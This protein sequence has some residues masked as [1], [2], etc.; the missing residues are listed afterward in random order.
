MDLT[1]QYMGLRLRSP[2][3]ASAAPLN[4]EIETLRALEDNGA[5]AV[6]LPSIFEEQIIAEQAECERATELSASGFAEAQTYFT[7]YNGYGFGAE[8]YLDMVRRAK[9]TIEIPVIASLNGISDAGWT[10][11]ARRLQE[12]GANALELNIYLIP[13]NVMTSGRDVEQHYLDVLAAV[14]AVVSIPVAVK[15]GPYFSS[16]GSMARALADGGADALVLFNRFYQPDFDVV[17]LRLS[18][19]LDLSTPAEMRLPLLWTAILHGR[20]SASL[21]ASTGVDSAEDVLKYL[22]AGADTVMTTSSLLRHGTGHMRKLVE[23]LAALLD[24]RNIRSLDQIRGRM[25]QQTI[26][27]PTAFERANYIHLLQGYHVA[28]ASSTA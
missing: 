5:G 14:K 25:S 3:I 19:A 26:K 23:G 1:T 27:N 8:R 2:L 6:V 7:V 12:A 16:I 11:Y 28:S 17:T 4:A 13:A 24:A 18:M 15:V 22:L 20:V 9:Q 10:D 21:A